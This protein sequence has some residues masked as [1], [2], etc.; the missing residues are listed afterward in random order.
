M[1]FKR[2]S[3]NSIGDIL[4]SLPAN[5]DLLNDVDFEGT[6]SMLETNPR[7]II[8]PLDLNLAT[9]QDFYGNST[10]QDIL[11]LTNT[12]LMSPN[13]KSK[14][15][16]SSGTSSSMGGHR[17]LIKQPSTPG[18]TD[19]DLIPILSPVTGSFLRENPWEEL[20]KTMRQG[21]MKGFEYGLSVVTTTNP[22]SALIH[23]LP[24]G[25]TISD[26]N[27]FPM[28]ILSP[29]R[30]SS[31]SSTSSPTKV[32]RKAKQ[33]VHEGC[34]RRAQSN[35][36]CKTHG[37]GARCQVEGCDKSSQG[38]GLCRAH[39][40]GK[41][42]RVPGCTKGTQRHGLCYLH[43]GIRRC[44]TEG[45]KKKDRGNG[46]CISHGGGRRC[47]VPGCNR[48]VRKGNHCQA[49]QTLLSPTSV[50]SPTTTI[51]EMMMHHSS[52]NPHTSHPH[53]QSQTIMMN[54]FRFSRTIHQLTT[55]EK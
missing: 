45:C 46:Y 12:N 41:K 4:N 50:T 53:P 44:I 14:I 30:T 23:P 21:S 2:Q 22:A 20:G 43:G 49:H 18:N 25:Y 24:N 5:L 34:T 7:E 16:S 33:C 3:S 38:G 37:G 1:E 13:T 36:R 52:T 9:S 10:T 32:Q 28:G 47:E 48:S 26:N 35:S 6:M 15:L 39:G 51:G 11:S 27:V 17:L 19:L 40:G 54:D 42:C 55:S 8:E 29:I 31:D